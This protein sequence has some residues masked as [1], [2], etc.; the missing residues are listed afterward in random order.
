MSSKPSAPSPAQQKRSRETG[1]KLIQAAIALLME[2]G[3]EACTAP[4]VAQRA[5][6]AVGSIY[7]RFPDKDGLV[8]EAVLQLSQTP[9]QPL[10]Q[11]ADAVA[12]GDL[13]TALRNYVD[14]IVR[15]YQLHPLLMQALFTLAQS[16]PDAE[17]RARLR[18]AVRRQIRAFAR[19]IVAR[20]GHALACA[21]PERAVVFALTAAS[22]MLRAVLLAGNADLFEPSMEL[23]EL[24][25]EATALAH[26]YLTAAH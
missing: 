18:A 25:R 15:A 16:H 21:D 13:P 8:K 2:G 5:G 26:A 4:A 17:F 24:L 7:R 23:E 10:E 12:T 6:V 1:E 22:N 9:E 3:L 20:H 14:T 11:M 19:A